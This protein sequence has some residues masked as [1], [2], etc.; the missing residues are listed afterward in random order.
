MNS[1][2]LVAA[3]TALL[4][5]ACA[6]YEVAEARIELEDEQGDVEV[7]KVS[8]ETFHLHGIADVND[9][10]D[11]NGT[12]IATGLAQLQT[13]FYGNEVYVTTPDGRQLRG[14]AQLEV[15]VPW[16]GDRDYPFAYEVR[17]VGGELKQEG[18]SI[19]R[20][21]VGGSMIIANKGCTQSGGLGASID[22]GQTFHFAEESG[23]VVDIT[24]TQPGPS[25][26]LAAPLC[27][28]DLVT[29]WMP[30]EK[31]VLTKSSLDLGEEK[32]PCR[33]TQSTA[34]VCGTYET[35]VEADGCDDWR[36]TI[37][38]WPNKTAGNPDFTLVIAAGAACGGEQRTCRSQY[39][40]EAFDKR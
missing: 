9:D 15:D 22:C 25:G 37:A 19:T 38:G 23:A 34:I 3:L 40:A 4:A 30:S 21:I 28:E 16:V 26:Q 13:G 14:E 29:Q 39:Y 36:V 6:N 7:V 10:Q 12:R 8:A 24:L 27:P 33:T 18:A 32:I 17:F 5:C 11:G 31:V 2:T 20:R 35:G 1:P